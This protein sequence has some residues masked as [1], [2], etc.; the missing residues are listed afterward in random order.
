MI[1]ITLCAAI[2]GAD[3][4]ADVER[5]GIAKQLWFERFLEFLA[6]DG[7]LSVSRDLW[8]IRRV[9]EPIDCES[10]WRSLLERFPALHPELVL[11]RRAGGA[12]ASI[13]RGES[14]P[15]SVIAPGGSLLALESLYQD[16][17]PAYRGR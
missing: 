15:L 3:N 14:E 13:L 7:A 10:L 9:P 12:L 6:T 4:W 16:D 8:R 1:T 17:K 5:F 2:C 11:L